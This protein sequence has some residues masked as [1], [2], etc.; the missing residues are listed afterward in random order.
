MG[1][2]RLIVLYL[3][4]ALL[5]AEYWFIER[6]REQVVAEPEVRRTRMFALEPDD[7]VRVELGVGTRRVEVALEDGAWTIVR[8]SDQQ[9]PPDLIRAFIEALVGAEIIDWAPADG[10]SPE[11]FG[12]G[13][14]AARVRMWDRAG[15]IWSVEIGAIAP[16]GTAVY[17]RQPE[18]VVAL[19][20]RNAQYY[21][22]LIVGAVRAVP[23][24][25]PDSAQPVASMRLTID[26]R[27]G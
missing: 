17:A 7:V 5:G 10:R 6:R 2:R 25:E 22:D 24:I 13:P 27:A 21:F 14:Q 16:T 9:I 1:W 8:P 26:R 19:L 18:G 15:T 12:F 20:G 3:V 11:A 23:T 4:A